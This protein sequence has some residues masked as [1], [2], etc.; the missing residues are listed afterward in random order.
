[1][2]N[3]S[4]HKFSFNDNFPDPKG[5]G[6]ISKKKEYRHPF[7]Q[8]FNKRTKKKI[9]DKEIIRFQKKMINDFLAILKKKE[10]TTKHQKASFKILKKN[11]VTL[12][13]QIIYTKDNLKRFLEIY[14][15]INVIY[16]KGKLFSKKKRLS[17]KFKKDKMKE[18]IEDCRKIF[19]ICC[20]AL[21]SENEFL[22]PNN[23]PDYG[24]LDIDKLINLV[25]YSLLLPKEMQNIVDR[26]DE[27]KCSNLEGELEEIKQNL[28]FLFT[29]SISNSVPI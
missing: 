18:H 20:C 2:S 7:K 16:L 22:S 28:H 6:K 4:S 24:L 15:R 21:E 1:M 11:I 25:L 3:L 5:E 13:N 8:Q 26:L 17:L 9:R 12:S 29:N 19:R 14:H 10:F 27:L 23:K